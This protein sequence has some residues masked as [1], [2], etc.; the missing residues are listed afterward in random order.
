MKT[1]LIDDYPGSDLM[2]NIPLKRFGNLKHL[3]ILLLYE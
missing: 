3:E 2:T 1:L